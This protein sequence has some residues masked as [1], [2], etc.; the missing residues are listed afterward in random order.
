MNLFEPEAP[1]VTKTAAISDC[2]LYRYRLTRRWGSGP[3]LP[4]VMLNPSTADA[5]IDDPTIRRCMGFSRR[6]GADG[7][8]VVNLFAYR[9]P[10]PKELW[11]VEPRQRHGLH[12]EHALYDIANEAIETNSPIVCAWGAG[13][14]D[15]AN[16]T[17]EWLKTRGA[18]LVCLGKTKEGHPRHPLYVKGDQPLMPFA[19]VG[20]PREQP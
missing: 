17:V 12:N 4:F 3:L 1:E 13:A 8:A 16:F 18:R 2:G 7:I 10:S 14:G 19:V 20:K 5:S 9:T 11:A 15:A 6:E